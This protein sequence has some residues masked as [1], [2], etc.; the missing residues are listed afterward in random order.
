MSFRA[1]KVA[2]ALALLPVSLLAVVAMVAAPP[3]MARDYTRS[4]SATISFGPSGGTYVS[5]TFTG[6]ATVSTYRPNTA[7][8]RAR[9]NIDEC[10]DANFANPH[11]SL[12]SACTPVNQVYDYPF[13]RLHQEL[14]LQ[15][16][17]ANRGHTSLNINVNVAYRGDVGCLLR[18][19]SWGRTMVTNYRVNC[20]AQN[21]E[22]GTNRPRMDYREFDTRG[23]WQACQAQ[24][25]AEDR[26]QA[27]VHKA[28]TTPDGPGHC[29]LKHGVPD[30]QPQSGFTSGVKIQLH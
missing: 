7:R 22:P 5:H 23:G 25:E 6:K 27:W 24:C 30:P 17:N 15:A 29:W 20:A 8:E 11:G 13:N 3:V 26:C 10:L 12:P 14:A 28:P 1:N 18:N 19:N 16:C 9:N 21:F 2:R 4:C